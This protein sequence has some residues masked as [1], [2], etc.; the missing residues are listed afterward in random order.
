[1]SERY[2]KINKKV[3]DG[4]I[5][6]SRQTGN[7]KKILGKTYAW[8]TVLFSPPTTKENILRMEKIRDLGYS[9]RVFGPN[10]YKRYDVYARKV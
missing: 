10:K 2:S 1:M 8:I 9:V 5:E 7:L 4:C 6:V 3:I